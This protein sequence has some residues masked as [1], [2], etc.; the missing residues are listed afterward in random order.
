VEGKARVV[1][2]DAASIWGISIVLLEFSC[3]SPWLGLLE[4]QMWHTAWLS[5]MDMMAVGSVPH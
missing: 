4:V 2:A 1:I 5:P 3:W